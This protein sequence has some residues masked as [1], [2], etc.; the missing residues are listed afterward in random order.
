MQPKDKSW[1]SNKES[2]FHDALA[3][4]PYFFR[5]YVP[6]ES[7]KPGGFGLWRPEIFWRD[8][9]AATNPGGLNLT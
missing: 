9:V 5:K 6:P 8:R 7:F 4:V 1:V 2:G 3:E